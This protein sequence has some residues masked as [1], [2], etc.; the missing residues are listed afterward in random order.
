MRQLCIQ[1]ASKPLSLDILL[2][3]DKPGRI[4]HPLC[5]LIDNWRYEE[6]SDEDQG[7]HQPVYDQL[8]PILLL[9]LVIV[10]RYDLSPTDLGVRSSDSFV[11]KLITRGGLGRPMEELDEQEMLHLDGWIKGLF[12]TDAGGLSDE[13]MSSCPPQSFYLLIATLFHQICLA[14]NSS[15]LTEDMLKSGFEC[16]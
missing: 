1:L 10:F 15:H 7:E 9:L 6:R 12:S 16:G 4:I 5:E 11:A 3:F 2:L 13:L 8:G 14:Y